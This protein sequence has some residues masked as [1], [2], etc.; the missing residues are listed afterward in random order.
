MTKDRNSANRNLLKKLMAGA[1][2]LAVVTGVSTQAEAAGHRAQ[3]NGFILVNATNMTG[4][5][6]NSGDTFKYDGNFTGSTGVF[7]APVT[8][9]E[10]KT[11]ATTPGDFSISNGSAA[12]TISA[13]TTAGGGNLPIVLEDGTTLI[14]DGANTY[15]GLGSVLA[16]NNNNGTLQITGNGFS[17]TATLGAVGNAIN[18]IEL[19]TGGNTATF[20]GAVTTTKLQ[21]LDGTTLN[22]NANLTGN[23]DFNNQAGTLNLYDGGTITGQVDSIANGIGGTLVFAGAG[24]VTQAIGANNGLTLINAN[25]AGAVN[26]GNGNAVKATLIK[27]SDAGAVV[28]AGGVVT[29]GIKF[30]AGGTFN[31]N[32]NLTGNIDFNN[33]AGTVNVDDAKTITGAVNSVANGTGGRLIF[34]GDGTVT[35]AIGGTNAL[36]LVRL[37]GDNTKAVEFQGAVKATTLN[38]TAGATAKLKAGG[39]I[40]TLILGDGDSTVEIGHAGAAATLT[41]N[42]EVAAIDLTGDNLNI[43]FEHADSVLRFDAKGGK[44]VVVTLDDELDPN[45]GNEGKLILNAEGDDAALAPISS[46]LRITGVGGALGV[47]GGNLLQQVTVSGDKIVTSEVPINTTTLA[48]LAGSRLNYAPGANVSLNA[49]TLAD[50]ASTLSLVGRAAN[51]TFTLLDD[52]DPGGNGKG[53]VILDSTVKN[54][55]LTGNGLKTLGT[56]GNHIVELRAIGANNTVTATVDLTNVN[57]VNVK[58]GGTLASQTKTLFDVAAVNIGEAAGAGTL[59]ADSEGQANIDVLNGKTITFAHDDSLLKLTNTTNVSNTV[60]TLKGILVPGGAPDDLKGNLEISATN[61]K[62]ITITKQVGQTIGT[63]NTH[64]LGSLLIS[65]DQ[66]VTVDTGVFA[67]KVEITN[68]ATVNFNQVMNLGAN[69]TLKFT[70]AG[71]TQSAAITVTNIDFNNINRNFSVKNGVNVNVETITNGANS[72]LTFVGGGTL[73]L[74]GARTVNLG[75][76]IAGE[77][78]KIVTLTQGTY[79]GNVQVAHAGGQVRLG[80]GFILNGGFNVAAGNAGTVKFLGAATVNGVLGGAGNALGAVTVAGVSTL[81]LKGS[82]NVASL[83]GVVGNAQTLKFINDGN[84]TVTG[85]VGL[86]QAFN[87]VEFNGAHQVKFQTAGAIGSPTLHFTANAD[88]VTKGFDLAG[89]NITQAVT[90][91]K[92]TVN[93]NQTLT[94]NT[95]AFGTLHVNG[96]KTINVNTAN[97]AA[98]ITTETLDEVTVNFGIDGTHAGTIGEALKKVHEINFNAGAGGLITVGAV[99]AT[100]IKVNANGVVAFGGAVDAGSF[101]FYDNA[102]EA[103]FGNINLGVQLKANIGGNG[104]ANFD[105]TT[106]S[107]DVGA[108]GAR[109][110]EANFA[111]SESHVGADIYANAIGLAGGGTITLDDASVFTGVT[112][113]G[114]NSILNLTEHDI[115]FK[116]GAVTLGDGTTIKTTVNGVNLGNFVAGAGSNITLNDKLKIEVSLAPLVPLP[117]NH[118][119]VTLIKKNGGTVALDLTKITVT[120]MGGA[121]TS[122][123]T[124]LDNGEL[125]LTNESKVAEVIS[126]SA[127]EEG[128]SDVI[129]EDIAQAFEDFTPGTDGESVVTLFNSFMAPDGSPDEKVISDGVARLS[130]TTANEVVNASMEQLA[131]TSNVLT[132]RLLDITATTLVSL[133]IQV[134]PVSVTPTGGSTVGAPTTG[135]QQSTGSPAAVKGSAPQQGQQNKASRVTSSAEVVGIAA[136]DDQDR[137]GAWMAPFYSRNTQKKRSASSGYKLDTYGGTFGFDTKASDELLIGLAFTAA[138]SDIKHKDFKSGDKTKVGSMLFSA[139][140]NYQFGNNWF[141]QGVL[142]VGNS[143]IKNRENRRISTTAYGIAEAQYSSMT[144]AGELIAG[145]NYLMKDSVIITP[146]FGIGYSRVNDASYKET[147]NVGAQLLNVTKKASQ[148]F[149]LVAG[150]RVTGMPFIVGEMSLSPD[151]H[152]SVRHDVIGKG[153]K[154]DAT[155]PGLRTLSEKAKLQKTY[156]NIGAGLRAT[157]GSMDYGAGV[158]TT[159]A[160]K[161][162]GVTGTVN[163]RVNF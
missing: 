33:Q 51:T 73:N 115:T 24:T 84:I 60:F 44:Q 61:N 101:K 157:Y 137:Y 104:I 128:L 13:V 70:A 131:M 67:K 63:D 35:Q 136:G 102:A 80:A 118:Q 66:N 92:L 134:A 40:S 71:N 32:N 85:D 147:G 162:V 100:D 111:A 103:S 46:S 160:K 151:L 133:P 62:T 18:L 74:G 126:A 3:A 36:T 87:V 37:D 140:S 14:L 59:I 69:S 146:T 122:W 86:L 23:V 29:A 17:T 141:A 5:N 142:S 53:I 90:G 81:Q 20:G 88:V 143:D 150:L 93:V 34:V 156:F 144:F 45:V 54:V 56:N 4:G 112:T 52:V 161:Y 152:A 135:G 7:L 110:A 94:G 106:I 89:T 82:V 30:M 130:N 57:A 21:F 145:Y 8:I 91:A 39:T 114:V 10:I 96:N 124:E 154:V 58:N 121:F 127:E 163:V 153:A 155:I 159:L 132:D 42:G 95:A 76:I 49:V 138:N 117:A 25:G 125:I 105:Q 41:F 75:N 113:T 107:E 72:S 9:A 108:D 77:N 55:T 97:F 15:A 43:S 19:N 2:A 78:G 148:K 16:K 68:T 116:G 120:K 38:V 26:L 83:D 129:T 119:R 1:S 48:I 11:L 98:N 139:Y 64:R 50:A 12:V 109:L 158:D 149:D 22:L 123:R 65:G 79:T 6:F 27:V 31:L 99:H 28:T 47:A